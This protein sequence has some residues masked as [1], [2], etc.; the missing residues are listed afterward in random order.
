MDSIHVTARSPEA[1]RH[2]HPKVIHF[3]VQ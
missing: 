3:E 2:H 1:E